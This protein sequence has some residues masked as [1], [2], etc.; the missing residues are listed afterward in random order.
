MC[1]VS[2]VRPRWL[3]ICACS[4]GL[5]VDTLFN[6]EPRLR[7]AGRPVQAAAPPTTPAG[8][9][10]LL[11]DDAAVFPPGLAPL[12]SAVAAHRRIRS[13][14][15]ADWI[16]PLLVPAG[17]HGDLLP[18]VGQTQLDE[19]QLAET[20]L[21]QAQLNEAQLE[22]AQGDRAQPL[23]IVLIAPAADPLPALQAAL[24]SLADVPGV[25]VVGVE[26]PLPPGTVNPRPTITALDA[27]LAP[28][29]GA[30]L[31]FDGSDPAAVLAALAR[32][33]S[34]SDRLL[35]GKFRTGGTTPTST[36]DAHTL[37]AVIAGAV[38]A[39]MPI[40]F[41]AGLHHAV[42]GPHGT[43]GS[44]QYGVLNVF[45][46]VHSAMAGDGA[47][48][49]PGIGPGATVGGGALVRTGEGAI[50]RELLSTDGPGLA[51]AVRSWSAADVAAVRSIFTSF[52]CCG[53]TEPLAELAELGVIDPWEAL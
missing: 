42:T 14:G 52:G 16:G 26:M 15:L 18:L 49:G 27:M 28:G 37:A 32:W 50:I 10:S 41:T 1:Q 17:R 19:T 20:L 29:M 2:P 9:V 25:S 4:N 7:N 51:T 21:I 45:A 47:E 3:H 53:V 31:E 35:R 43:G 13:S 48:A 36:P 22:A 5:E 23:E 24:T 6:D 38:A 30:A 11:V 33:R 44:M 12:P 39:N 34:A 8:L 40:K 46:A